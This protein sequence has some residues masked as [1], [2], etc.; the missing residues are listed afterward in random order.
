MFLRDLS[1]ELSDLAVL[2]HGYSARAF[3]DSTHAVVERYFE[4]LPWG[5]VRLGG[6]AKVIVRLGP[7]P[8][9]GIGTKAAWVV[10]PDGVDFLWLDELGLGLDLAQY[11]AADRKAQQRSLLAALHQ[12][13]LVVARRSGDDPQAAPQV[14]IGAE[15]GEEADAAAGR[16]EALTRWAAN[17]ASVVLRVQLP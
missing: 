5:K 1:V 9:A 14:G 8:A 11:A 17:P 6:A 16:E 3:S 7:R 2:P 10:Y 12:G 13:C 15:A 4:L